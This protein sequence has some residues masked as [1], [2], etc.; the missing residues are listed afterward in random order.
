V[1]LRYK[2]KKLERKLTNPKE[3]I[4]AFGQLARNVNQRI[5]ELTDAEIT[6]VSSW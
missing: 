3:L 6:S 5:K 2:T 4:K 1:E